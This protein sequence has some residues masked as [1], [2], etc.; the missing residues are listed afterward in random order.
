MK[1]LSSL[2]IISILFSQS[3]WAFHDI[4]LNNL[5]EQA[6]T[7]A[8]ASDQNDEASA[9]Y[10]H[11]GHASAH[12]VG[13]LSKSNFDVYS[14]SVNNLVSVKNITTSISYQPPVPPP[15]FVMPQRN[16]KNA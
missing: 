11:C 12:L 4:E 13:L 10:D 5:Q 2:L 7:Q 16:L 6:Y 15:N 3:A 14:G 9:N 8:Q 1:R